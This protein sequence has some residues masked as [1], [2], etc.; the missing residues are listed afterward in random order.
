MVWGAS[1]TGSSQGQGASLPCSSL[2]PNHS[3]PVTTRTHPA[4]PQPP[5]PNPTPCS[6]PTAHVNTRSNHSTRS[7]QQA[8]EKMLLGALNRRSAR[9]LRQPPM[10][11]DAH[12]ISTPI[13]KTH[14]HL[15]TGSGHPHPAMHQRGCSPL[16]WAGVKGQ[17]GM[18]V[19]AQLQTLV[20]DEGV[21]P[22][23]SRYS[24]QG[25]HQEPCAMTVAVVARC[26]SAPHVPSK[27]GG[28]TLSYCADS[29][30][31]LTTTCTSP[32]AAHTPAAAEPMVA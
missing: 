13:S 8:G 32:I 24:K 29:I 26:G 19:A 27:A 22:T 17:A 14:P 2:A 6:Q 1:G 18:V 23:C 25:A 10:H 20:G 5:Q 11:T 30:P 28:G 21:G 16:G 3:Q 7:Q 9:F 31:P 12:A 15:H 4:Q